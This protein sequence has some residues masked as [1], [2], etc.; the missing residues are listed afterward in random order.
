MESH[1]I[2]DSLAMDT[3][4]VPSLVLEQGAQIL[5]S[6]TEG[7]AK[8]SSN[9]TVSRSSIKKYFAIGNFS[10]IQRSTTSR[11]LT[12]GSRVSV[13]A[14]SHPTDWLSTSEFQYRDSSAFYGDTLDAAHQ[15]SIQDHLLET[16]IG[17]DVWIGDNAFVKSGVNI[18]AGSIVG[19][20]AIVTKDIEPYSI[21]AG[22]PSRIIRKRFGD[23][24]IT[25]L[26]D[27][28]WW[29]L[30]IPQLK[31]VRF[32]NIELALQDVIHI[33]QSANV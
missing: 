12:I 31:C 4:R 30:D 8:L 11:Y 13:G 25:Q 23:K 32:S 19:A 16:I 24:I 27:V 3:T 9:S 7:Y 6:T 33:K 5:H 1:W 17:P 28:Q 18:G 15:F 20:G 29:T 22:N 21:V 10:F 14:F 26:L 2:C